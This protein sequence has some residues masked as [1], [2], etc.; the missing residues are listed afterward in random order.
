[1]TVQRRSFSTASD[2]DEPVVFDINGVEFRCRPQ[3]SS[4]IILKMG[5]LL[6]G[7]QDTLENVSVPE[8]I[9]V[10][11]DFFQHAIKPED[12]EKFFTMLDDPDTPVPITTLIDIVK[13][14]ASMYTGNRPTGQNSPPTPDNGSHGGGSTGSA[15]PEV[16][17]SGLS[18]QTVASTSSSSG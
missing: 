16:S 4:G 18:P 1:M 13:W 10:I 5:E 8:M 9:K 17:I 12:R 14:L 11:K 7:D 2:S 6:G 3:I 15:S